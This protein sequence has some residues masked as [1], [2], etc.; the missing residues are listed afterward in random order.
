M[1]EQTGFIFYRLGTGGGNE[2][3]GYIK[4]GEFLD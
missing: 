2:S 3:P 1:G 4:C